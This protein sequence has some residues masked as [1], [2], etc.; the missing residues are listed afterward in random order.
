MSALSDYLENALL[1]HLLRAATYTRPGTLHLSLHTASPGESGTTGEVSGGAYAR[2]AIANNNTNFPQASAVGT[3]V[4]TNGAIITFPAATADWGTVTHWAIYDAASGGTNM[5]AH[6]ALSVPRFVKNGDTPRV[7]AAALTM[8]FSNAASGGLSN[9]AARKLL[10]HVFGGPDYTPPTAVFIAL[11][12]ALSGESLTEWGDADYARQN[13]A[14]AAAS[15][16][17]CSNSA[18]ETFATSVVGPATTITHFGLYDD[19]SSGNLLMTGPM[20]TSRLCEIGDTVTFGI[21]GFVATLQ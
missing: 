3:P 16:G 12:T 15:G 7:A 17:A 19:A 4:K 6:G 9:F 10:D 14:F 1:N 11:G 8:S 18:L 21:G 2:A 13:T 20:S 5:L